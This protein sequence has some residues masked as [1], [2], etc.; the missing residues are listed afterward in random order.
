[1]DQI[2]ASCIGV[3]PV[4]SV[5]ILTGD[6]ERITSIFALVGTTAFPAPP[7]SHAPES[8]PPTILDPCYAINPCKFH[9]GFSIEPRVARPIS[10]RTADRIYR[11]GGYRGGSSPSPS[12]F[13]T[14]VRGGQERPENSNGRKGAYPLGHFPRLLRQCLENRL[15]QTRLVIVKRRTNVAIDGLAVCRATDRPTRQ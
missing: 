13:L 7:H 6:L 12:V 1:M 10:R 2:R 8:R 9:W 11:R 15:A 4:C 5:V 14:V 3:I